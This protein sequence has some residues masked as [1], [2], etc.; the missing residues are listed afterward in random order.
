MD[1]TDDIHQVDSSASSSDES[2]EG[3]PTTTMPS[4]TRELTALVKVFTCYH[5]Y[6]SLM[7]CAAQKLQ[8]ENAEYR[9]QLRKF[10]SGSGSISRTSSPASATNPPN[11]LEDR[12]DDFN[13][14]GCAFCVLNELWIHSSHLNQPYP[15]NLRDTGPWHLERYRDEKTKHEGIIA[16]VYDFVPTHFHKYLEGSPFFANKVRTI[17]SP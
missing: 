11:P 17:V 15:E 1:D 6:T 9:S 3:H 10:T 4:D 13:K 16:E 5:L 7:L 12:A 8:L 2:V 14:L